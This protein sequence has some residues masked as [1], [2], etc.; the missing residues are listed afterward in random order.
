MEK[1]RMG[2]MAVRLSV[3]FSSFVGVDYTFPL[4]MDR[5]YMFEEI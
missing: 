1:W 4:M 5:P 2:R 3:L